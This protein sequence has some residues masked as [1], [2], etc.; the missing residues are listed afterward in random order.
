V[1]PDLRQ[2]DSESE[3][4]RLSRRRKCKVTQASNRQPIRI[5]VADSSPI[6]SQL[7]AE[8]IGRHRGIEI[9]WFGSIPEDV[10]RLN[11][12]QMP[13][14]ALISARI[15]EDPHHGF[16]ILEKLR[17]EWPELKAVILLDSQTSDTIVRAFRSGASGVFSKNQAINILCKCIKAVHD[18]QIWADSK[19]LGYVLAALSGS[20]RLSMTGRLVVLSRREREVVHSLAD[21][22]TNREIGDRLKISPHTVKNY[23]F[24]IFEKLGVS[25]RVEV[26]SV[27]LSRDQAA[28]QTGSNVL[29]LPPR[30][31]QSTQAAKPQPTESIVQV[32]KAIATM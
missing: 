25:S 16:Y 9:Q 11:L 3:F 2:R 32:P 13:D 22:L 10:L 14:V 4:P 31:K 6:T 12:S 30:K 26:I 8:A 29:R 20:P 19:E 24:K 23:M 7:L 15:G 27:A 21:G 1:A 18:G 5:L 28:N 17:A